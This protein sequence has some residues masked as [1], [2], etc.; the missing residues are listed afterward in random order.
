MEKKLFL[1]LVIM[2]FLA[3]LSVLAQDVITPPSAEELQTWFA[4]I[5]G[6]KGAGVLAIVY[7]VVQG[8]ALFFRTALAKFAGIYQLLIINGLTLV[9]GVLAMKL[10]GVDWVAALLS[11][12][13]LAL[14]Q[15]FINQA[16]KQF[17]KK[18]ADDKAIAVT[19]K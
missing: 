19:V 4:S 2:T 18:A 10:T 6:L 7:F 17:T 8:L 5:G 12:G 9:L 1:A 14:I 15:L 3:C 13:N 11:S 16:W